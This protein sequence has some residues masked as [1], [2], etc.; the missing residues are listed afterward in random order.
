[1]KEKK[2]DFHQER[3]RLLLE[4]LGFLSCG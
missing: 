4:V 2:G 1:L 3:Q